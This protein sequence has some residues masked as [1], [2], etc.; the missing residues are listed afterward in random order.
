MFSKSNAF[1]LDAEPIHFPPLAQRKMG[2]IFSACWI[3]ICGC[4]GSIAR[5]IGGVLGAIVRAVNLCVTNIV[6]AR[7]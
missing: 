6:R 5:V 1:P 3:S 7:K 4:V 2:N